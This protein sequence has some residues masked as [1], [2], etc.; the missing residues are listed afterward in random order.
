MQSL[1]SAI[2][3]PPALET[4]AE[5]GQDVPPVATPRFLLLTRRVNQKPARRTPSSATRSP[6]EPTPC[7]RCARLSFLTTSSGGAPPSSTGAPAR[8]VHTSSHPPRSPSYPAGRLFSR[9]PRRSLTYT[10][11][12]SSFARR[13][14]YP[15][16]KE[17]NHLTPRPDITM[18]SMHPAIT[19]FPRP[20]S[21][22][23]PGW[24]VPRPAQVPGENPAC[25]SSLTPG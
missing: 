14:P 25:P 8:I 17:E 2:T 21:P 18:Q 10:L 15:G 22:A 20:R 16:V 5:R 1:H 19:L 6:A 13:S 9:P 7:I 23:P 4:T 24:P 12:H 3:T 11:Q